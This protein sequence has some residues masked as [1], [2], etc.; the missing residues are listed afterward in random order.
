M[1]LPLAGGAS[2]SPE[3]GTV[4]LAHLVYRQGKPVGLPCFT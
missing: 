1:R 3:T 4:T 2:A